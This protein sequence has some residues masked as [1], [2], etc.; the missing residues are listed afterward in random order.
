MNLQTIGRKATA[1]RDT[2]ALAVLSACTTIAMATPA[3]P[4]DT[5]LANVSEKVAD[6][7]AALV[8]V[9]AIS[10]VFMVAVKY[11]KKIRGAA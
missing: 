9:A 11:V 8:T 2:I 3:D 1:L 10:V 5:A 7:A 4:F 6:Y